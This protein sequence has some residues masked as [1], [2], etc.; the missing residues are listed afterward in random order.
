MVSTTGQEPKNG[1]CAIAALAAT[2]KIKYIRN[3]SANG[4]KRN[5]VEDTRRI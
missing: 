1:T 5:I 4:N 2:I 3:I